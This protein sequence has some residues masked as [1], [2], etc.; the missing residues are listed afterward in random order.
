[1]P[2][3]PACSLD[4]FGHLL[5]LD[6]N[7]HLHRKTG[8]ILRILDRGVTS[9]QVRR[10]AGQLVSSRWSL[11]VTIAGLHVPWHSVGGSK[12]RPWSASH[13]HHHYQHQQAA[14]APGV[15]SPACLPACLQDL[16]VI[17]LFDVAPQIADIAISCT[18]LA[19]HMQPWAAIIVL[20]TVCSYVPLT[21][22]ITERRGVIRKR[23]NGAQRHLVL[24]AQPLQLPSASQAPV[25]LTVLGYKLG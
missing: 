3:P 13:S 6:L 5:H 4:V 11:A 12:H 18:Y 14:L 24:R 16:V 25:W 8:Q 9:I 23:M 22:C 1:M 2:P 19:I 15:T 20:A 10:A 7:F 17:L 21:I